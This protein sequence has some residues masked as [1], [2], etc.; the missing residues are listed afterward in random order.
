VQ[1]L[2]LETV[3]SS[4]EGLLFLAGD[5]PGA[6]A[7]D[8]RVTGIEIH[9]PGGAISYAGRLVVVAA[10]VHTAIELEQVLRECREAVAVIMPA[11]APS[12]IDLSGSADAPV[13]LRR[14]PWVSTDA[15]MRALVA[16]SRLPGSEDDAGA[17]LER[18]AALAVHRHDSALLALLRGVTDAATPAA[19]VGLRPDLDHVVVAAGVSAE[20][21]EPYSLAMRAEFADERTVRSEEITFSVLTV[22]SKTE[23]AANVVG[24]LRSRMGRA[25]RGGQ[26][27]PVGVGIVVP[28]VYTLH[29]SAA[30]AREILRALRFKLGTPWESGHTSL[31][32]AGADDV[33]DA[34]VLIRAADALRPLGAALAERL[35]VLAQYDRDHQSVLLPSVLAAL[36]HRSN[37]TDAA[38]SLGVHPN[39]LRGRLERVK[40]VA[41][42]DLNEPVSAMRTMVAF[43]ANPEA[44]NAA[45]GASW[46]TGLAP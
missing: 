18:D 1:V 23:N 31:R 11:D 20:L 29:E 17:V 7:L 15:L 3:L 8:R 19:L 41:G 44:H 21:A 2:D 5:I 16:V 46:S 13:V 10:P 35:M 40:E 9:Q 45:R 4:A 37:V 38:R 14:S 32:V 25:I 24:R 6:S 27:L 34:L 12:G 42:I 33:P 28:G 30:A 26:D 36:E 22:D 39:S 43:L